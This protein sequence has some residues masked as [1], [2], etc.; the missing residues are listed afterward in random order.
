M[1][2]ELQGMTKQENIEE[3]QKINEVTGE[4]H[5]SYFHAQLSIALSNAHFGAS[6]DYFFDTPEKF[7]IP[8]AMKNT[9]LKMAENFRFAEIS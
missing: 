7:K 2:A 8:K 4:L 1:P 3:W 6:K 9:L 5:F